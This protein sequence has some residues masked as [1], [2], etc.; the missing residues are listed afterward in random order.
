MKIVQ[1]L[2]S[3]TMV[4]TQKELVYYNLKIFIFS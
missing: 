2:K 3:N 4:V 1:N